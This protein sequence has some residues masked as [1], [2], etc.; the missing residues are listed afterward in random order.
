MEK[1]AGIKAEAPAVGRLTMVFLLALALVVVFSLGLDRHVGEVSAASPPRTIGEL[2]IAGQYGL[3]YAPLIVAEKRQIFEK[4]GLKVEWKQFGSGAAVREALVSG[5]LDVGFMAIPP[6]LIGWDKGMPAKVALG[7][8][9]VPFGLVTYDPSIKSLKDFGPSDKIAVPS[10]GSVQHI[11]LAMAA[12]KELGDA[13][14]LD[15]LIVAMAH[16]D[17]AAALISKRGIT[18]HFATPPYVFEELSQPGFHQVLNE[19]Q[20]FGKEFSFNVAVA[21]KKFHDGNPAAYAAFVL[22]VE[23]SMA[24]INE[25]K[26]EAA[27]LLAPEFNLPADK[28]LKYLNWSGVNYTTTVYGLMGFADFMQKA[29]YIKKVPTR[30]SDIAWENVLATVGDRGGEPGPLELLQRR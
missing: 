22:G 20:A 9:N 5:E 4:Y 6:F 14:A 24:W 11:I 10:P 28:V 17:A 19:T 8:V 12:Q 21:T 30:M 2:R 3:V 26:R 15:R 7:F 29:G 18:A 13:N 23:E 1:R 16:P 27:Q 25:N